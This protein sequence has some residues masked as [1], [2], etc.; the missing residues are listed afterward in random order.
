[1]PVD[2][3]HSH[4][5]HEVDSPLKIPNHRPWMDSRKNR[6]TATSHVGTE[7]KSATTPAATAASAIGPCS[8]WAT[9]GRGTSR[10][11]GVASS[12]KKPGVDDGHR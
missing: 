7:R 10:M 3:G 5:N 12:E 1:M 6:G 2:S 9:L 8:I 4:V 11:D